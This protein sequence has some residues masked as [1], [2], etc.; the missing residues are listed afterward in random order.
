VRVVQLLNEQRRAGPHPAGAALGGRALLT[1]G[2]NVTVLPGGRVFLRGDR[3]PGLIEH[4][5]SID[6]VPPEHGRYVVFHWRPSEPV[7]VPWVEVERVRR[8]V[9]Y[10]RE[11]VVATL[12]PASAR[13]GWSVSGLRQTPSGPT[14]PPTNAAGEDEQ[15]DG[16]PGELQRRRPAQ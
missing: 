15:V 4:Y 11:P 2:V 7:W 5:A 8:Q 1:A 6:T 3:E 13:G 12:A 14:P 9:R 10:A 16:G